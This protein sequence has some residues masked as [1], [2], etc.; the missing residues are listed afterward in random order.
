MSMR[1][2]ASKEIQMIT[3]EGMAASIMHVRKQPDQHRTAK[4]GYAF[5]NTQNSSPI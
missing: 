1:Q 4:P 2:V 3:S 5:R